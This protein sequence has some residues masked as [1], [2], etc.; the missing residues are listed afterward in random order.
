[1]K[2]SG[3]EIEYPRFAL[4]V[5]EAAT[6]A[7]VS[8]PTMYQWMKISGFPAFKIGGCV[9]IPA[10]AFAAWLEQQTKENPVAGW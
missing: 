6:L 3:T 7:G 9:R 2:Q 8:R 5:T 10:Q 4:T 1:M